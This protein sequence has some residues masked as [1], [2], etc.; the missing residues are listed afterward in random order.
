MSVNYKDTLNLPKTDFPMK[1]DLP[2]REPDRLK[3]WDTD[4]IYNQILDARKSSPSFILHDGPPFANGDAHMGHALNMTLKD[5]VLKYRNMAGYHSPFVPGWDCHGLPIEFKVTKELGPKAR[6]M[7]PAQIRSQCDAM[8]RKYIGIQR[9]QFKRLGVFGEWENPYL[10][11]DPRYEAEVIRLFADLV[12]KN[13]VYQS[14]KP[15]YWST[16]AQ[17]A[18]AEAEVEYQNHS[19]PAID[20]TFE[21]E[22]P[23]ALGSALPS[24]A[25]TC[26]VIWT[27]TPWTLPSN[28]AIA[29]SPSINYDVLTD[30]QTNLIVA[31]ALSSR[32]LSVL[33]GK[34]FKVGATVSG[35]ELLQL[36]YKHSFVNRTGCPI[37]D[38]SDFIT[39]DTGTGLVHIAPGHGKDDYN[40]GRH[41]GILSP[42]D[43][44]GKFTAECGVPELVGQYVFAANPFIIENIL[45]PKGVLLHVENYEHTYPHC[46]RS[47][48]PIIFRSVEQWFIDIEKSGLREKSLQS[49]KSVKWVPDW[50]QNRITGAV[51]SRGDWCISRQRTWG[52]PLPAFYRKET[53]EAVLKPALIRKLADLVEKEGTNVWFEK[54]AEDLGRALG[55]ESPETLTKTNDT[56]DVWI[57]SGSSHR[58]VAKTHP[59]IAFPV[60]LYLEG[61]DQH[62]GWFQSSLLTSV[63]TTGHAPYK[64]VVT[65]GFVI[66]GDKLKKDNVKEKLSKSKQGGYEKPT[67]LMSFVNK[68]GADIL[69][70]WV[71]S[72]NYQNDVPWSEEIFKH[73][74]DSYRRIRNTFRIL[75]ANLYD[76]NPATDRV[77]LKSGSTAPLLDRWIASRLQG[78]IA[79]CI[80]AYEAYEFHRVYHLINN[81]CTVELSSLYV[82]ITKDRMYCDAP[83]TLRR[84][85]TQTVMH[86]TLCALARLLAPIMPYTCDEIWSFCQPNESSVH[87]QLMP[88]ANAA[89]RDTALEERFAELL[90]VREIAAVELEKARQSKLIGKSIEARVVLELPTT[91]FESLKG[92]EEFLTEWM[93]VSQVELKSGDSIKATVV[94][95]LGKKCARSWKWDETVGTDPEFPDISRRDAEAVRAALAGKKGA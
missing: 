72:E 11:I 41:L 31:S 91:L 49:I 39:T 30:G 84:R 89:L 81:F 95:P 53:R 44:D 75:H 24:A 37:L 14:K 40:V 82:D 25:K 46:W 68:Y 17:T 88:Q 78:L 83:E 90:K 18:L 58:A 74:S 6:T 12:E 76:F 35:K 29:A 10:T 65:N 22:N 85:A 71:A 56:I 1:A 61:S 48:T 93:I 16:G 69:R 54:S 47:K 36:T 23:Q 62:R 66:D 67:D 59:H 51:E 9:E 19:T 63:A 79:D 57:D 55:I 27:T 34:G 80:A 52:I 28:L 2:L 5:I 60:D 21:V 8:A 20:V 33:E 42:V 3:K 70:L 4:G 13:L 77:D 86:D 32:V 15:V 87:I 50:G 26:L 45:K 92:Q 43:D 38:G 73:V 7:T 94:T 64:A